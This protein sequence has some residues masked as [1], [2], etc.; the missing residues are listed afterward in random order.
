MNNNI[1][2]GPGLYLWR[3]SPIHWGH[4]AVA[5]AMIQKCKDNC[6]FILW[7]VNAPQSLKH[8]FSAEEREKFIKIL[9]PN[10]SII[11]QNDVRNQWSDSENDQ[12]R[13]QQLD[14]NI[15]QQFPWQYDNT[16][17]Y[18]GCYEDVEFFEKDNRNIIYMDRFDGTTPLISATQIRQ[19]LITLT[20]TE[21]NDNI[22]IQRLLDANIINPKIAELLLSTFIPKRHEFEKK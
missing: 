19:L 21:S 2:Q 6:A 14:H 17:F 1:K 11:R 4:E 8:F 7:S 15:E 12:L 13:L 16:T 20:L 9:Y 10:I 3:F 22:R 5:N 18:G